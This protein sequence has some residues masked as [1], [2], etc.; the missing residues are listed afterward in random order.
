MSNRLNLNLLRMAIRR[1]SSQKILVIHIAKTAGTSLRIMLENE[2]GARFIYP[3][4]LYLKNSPNQWYPSGS[5]MLENYSKLPF[6]RVLV[7][8]FTA[9]MADLLPRPYQTATFLREPIQRSLSMIAHFSRI[10][11]V[12]APSL[13]EDPQFMSAN[14]A[15]YQTRVLGADRVCEPG[16]VKV[17]DENVLNRAITRLETLDFVGLTERFDESCQRF[18][19]RFRTR[20][21][22]FVRRENVRRPTGSELAEHI[23][24]IE[25]FLE[26]DRILY[27]AAVARFNT[28]CK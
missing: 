14:I 4:R 26:R 25:Q 27:D 1:L 18:D 28:L 3:G 21:S 22:K 12:S 2:Y 23:P 10:L 13:I 24:Y 17:F 20:I 9:A 15:D 7:G 16:Q 6:H 5:E 8:H 19:R 11:N